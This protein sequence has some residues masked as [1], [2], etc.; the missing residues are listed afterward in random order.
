MK[1]KYAKLARCCE[2][3]KIQE[4][5]LR[6]LTVNNAAKKVKEGDWLIGVVP[7]IDNRQ[8]EYIQERLDVEGTQLC[9]IK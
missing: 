1:S 8:Y 9:G 2:N 6:N 5:S 4:S 3:I 7:F